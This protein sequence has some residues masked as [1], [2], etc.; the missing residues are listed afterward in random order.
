VLYCNLG[1]SESV[2]NERGLDFHFRFRFHF[3]FHFHF[4]FRL[5]AAIIGDGKGSYID[6]VSIDNN[7][8]DN[9]NASRSRP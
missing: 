3:H 9:M 2:L 6:D 5:P 4:H 1:T 7:Y 8:S